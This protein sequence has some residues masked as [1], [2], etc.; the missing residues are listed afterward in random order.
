MVL[1]LAE[2]YV[3]FKKNEINLFF[4][5]IQLTTLLVVWRRARVEAGKPVT[6]FLQELRQEMNVNWVRKVISSTRD[7]I[8]FVHNIHHNILTIYDVWYDII[9]DMLKQCLS[10]DIGQRL[11]FTVGIVRFI[12]TI[13]LWFIY[14]K[15]RLLQKYNINNTES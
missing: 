2:Y 13:C 14:S 11:Y 4:Y 1:L 6:R 15:I 5:L 10:L 12:Y 3:T 7:M 9:F 8:P